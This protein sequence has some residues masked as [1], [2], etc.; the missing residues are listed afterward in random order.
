MSEL[1]GQNKQTNKRKVQFQLNRSIVKRMQRQI[2]ERSKRKRAT[3][4]TRRKTK[5]K[6]S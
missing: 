3:W 1:N 6:L 2:V 4:P 5:Q